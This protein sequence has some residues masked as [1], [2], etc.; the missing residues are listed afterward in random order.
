[1]LVDTF[2]EQDEHGGVSNRFLARIDQILHSQILGI[3]DAPDAEEGALL[4]RT[5]R[6][7]VAQVY[8]EISPKQP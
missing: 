7:E 4:A 5:L 2:D 1:M 3:L 6:M 8:Q